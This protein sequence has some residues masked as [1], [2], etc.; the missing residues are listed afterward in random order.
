MSEANPQTKQEAE[1]AQTAAESDNEPKYL[2]RI[3]DKMKAYARAQGV[4]PNSDEFRQ[5]AGEVYQATDGFNPE[6]VGAVLYDDPEEQA[7]YLKALKVSRE[8]RETMP[9]ALVEAPGVFSGASEEEK[10]ARGASIDKLASVVGDVAKATGSEAA[11]KKALNKIVNSNDSAE[12]KAQL[13]KTLLSAYG[14]D[15]SDIEAM[16]VS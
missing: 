6:R 5:F 9:G 4:D 15:L 16:G 3:M 11:A 8:L 12:R 2:G 14:V 13:I 1:A 10:I 7:A